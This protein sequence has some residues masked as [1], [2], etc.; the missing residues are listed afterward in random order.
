MFARSR[1]AQF[2]AHRFCAAFRQHSS[3]ACVFVFLFYV[4]V[5]CIQHILVALYVPLDD[6]GEAAGQCLC[7]NVFNVL[8]GH[9]TTDDISNNPQLLMCC[10]VAAFA[11]RWVAVRIKPKHPR[12]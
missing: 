5:K 1:R 11:T 10:C 9:S 12:K 4:L 2:H 3:D 8:L 6:A 7:A